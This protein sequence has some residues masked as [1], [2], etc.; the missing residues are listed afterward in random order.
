MIKRFF[1]KVLFFSLFLVLAMSS[2]ARELPNRRLFIEGTATR[3]DHLDFFLT[4]FNVE[5][6]GTGYLLAETKENA[7]Y[8]FRFNVTTNPDWQ[9]AATP[10]ETQFILTVS[11]LR[12]SDSFEI[13]T[14]DFFFDTI[15]E[16]LDHNQLIFLRAARLIP[17]FT[18]IDMV[19]V[20]EVLEV[21]VIQEVEVVREVQVVR[22][23]RSPVN[24][25]W[26]NKWLYLRTSMDYPIT[27]YALKSDGLF[28]GLAVYE[29]PFENPG[30]FATE[31]HQVSPMP[32][33][34]VGLEMQFFNFMSLELNFQ[35]SMGDTRNNN[36]INM[37]AGAELKIPIKLFQNFVI[38]PY[39]A[40]VYPLNVSEDVFSEFPEYAIGGGVQVG[41]VGGRHGSFFID[42]KYMHSFTDAVMYN[43]HRE[44]FPEPPVIHY[45]RF[46]FGFGIG[47]K[48]GL[49][50]RPVRNRSRFAVNPERDPNNHVFDF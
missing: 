20:Q 7:G 14:F 13:F 35:L 50:D 41:T 31:T 4:S 47:Y 40:F 29:G 1:Y 44:L 5:A 33:M 45:Q 2:F 26:K 11:L 9:N 32:G 6:F 25:D 10:D 37:A 24:S 3:P 22:E 42:I 48:V 8:I 17:P 43:P 21:P 12:N 23:I 39:F 15:E 34:T 30:S 38:G 19:I 18:E 28:G 16:M 49:F 36:F 46:V 27:F